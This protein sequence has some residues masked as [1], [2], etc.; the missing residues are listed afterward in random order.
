MLFILQAIYLTKSWCTYLTFFIQQILTGINHGR[1]TV[2]DTGNRHHFYSV[3]I[4]TVVR[5]NVKQGNTTTNRQ[6]VLKK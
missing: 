1:G 2:S 4:Y 5:G 6:N 3:G